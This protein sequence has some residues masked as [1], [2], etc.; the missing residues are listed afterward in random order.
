LSLTVTTNSG[1]EA[2]YRVNAGMME[3]GFFLSPVVDA[4]QS[5]TRLFDPAAGWAESQRVR[6]IALHVEKGRTFAWS[7]VYFI[8]FQEYEY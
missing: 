8:C 2:T 3:S 5:F 4:N 7:K 6:S 1:E